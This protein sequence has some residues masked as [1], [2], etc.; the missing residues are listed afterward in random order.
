M[1]DW[2]EINNRLLKENKEL[3]KCLRQAIDVIN[4]MGCC[5][6]DGEWCKICQQQTAEDCD[7]YQTFIWERTA[8]AKSL[9]RGQI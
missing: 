7:L 5:S 6:D 2:E 8:F 1:A 4:K 9:I 3:K